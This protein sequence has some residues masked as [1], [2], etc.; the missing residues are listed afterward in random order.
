MKDEFTKIDLAIFK[1]DEPVV[2]IKWSLFKRLIGCFSPILLSELFAPDTV[3]E[4]EWKQKTTD[5]I[6]NFIY[7]Y[8]KV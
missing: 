8:F 5:E 6:L 3:S 2:M 1:T 4:I 7:G